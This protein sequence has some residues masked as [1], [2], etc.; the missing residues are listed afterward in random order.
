MCMSLV[1]VGGGACR[2]WRDFLV[3]FYHNLKRKNCFTKDDDEGFAKIKSSLLLDCLKRHL[4]SPMH[5]IQKI[6][7]IFKVI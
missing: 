6:K 3:F 4:I 2:F 7:N 5:L 1:D